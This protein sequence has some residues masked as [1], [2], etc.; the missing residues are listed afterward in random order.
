MA[1]SRQA[2]AT[3]TM[4]RG[5]GAGR[6][7]DIGAAAVTI[8]REAQCD[9]LVDGTWVSRQHA[10]IAWTGTE[11]IIE[12]LGSTNGTFVNGERI[13][14]PRALKSGDLLQLGEQVE[15]AFQVRV[16]APV[17][18]EPV[19]PGITPSPRSSTDPLR[20]HEPPSE[21]IPAEEGSSVRRR[22]TRIWALAL[23][24]L[25]FIL[26][27]G[28]GAYYLLSDK[29]QRV[30]DTT[31]EQAAP[32]QPAT[33][34]PTPSP[35]PIVAQADATFTGSMTISSRGENA[36]ADSGEIELMTSA[37]G[38]ALVSMSYSLFEG[39]CT[40]VSG[41]SSTTMTGSSKST[42]FFNEPVPIMNGKFVIDF[43]GIRA[44]GNL[45]SPSE[46]YGE[47]TINKEE[48][49]TSPSYQ[50]FVCQYGTWTWT[51]SVK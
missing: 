38:A 21:S 48:I 10:R 3:L 36:S 32:P 4:T 16:S 50:K 47:V 19:R 24:G 1:D 35:T 25:L 7:F 11:Y 40:Y 51:A 42:L 45:N 9:V 2:A 14:G 8:G 27:F 39:K 13:G 31:T 23:L 37:D 29:E 15:L 30:A 46:A 49:T 18:E 44:K 5:P 43:M 33:A 6:R 34:K 26:I 22:R 17:H 12:D 28:G 20:A 41:S